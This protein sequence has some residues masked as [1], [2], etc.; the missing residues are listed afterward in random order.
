MAYRRQTHAFECFRLGWCTHVESER[1]P[2]PWHSSQAPR[3][4]VAKLRHRMRQRPNAIRGVGPGCPIDGAGISNTIHDRSKLVL[5]SWPNACVLN[6]GTLRS[7][8]GAAE[9]S[10]RRTRLQPGGPEEREPRRTRHF[11]SRDSAGKCC[12]LVRKKER[13][14]VYKT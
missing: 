12:W 14:N 3:R 5:R 11:Y 7:T 13:S 1:T 10:V 4:P 9:A 6:K 2:R 8:R